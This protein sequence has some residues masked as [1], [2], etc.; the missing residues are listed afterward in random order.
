MKQSTYKALPLIRELNNMSKYIRKY[1]S[2]SSSDTNSLKQICKREKDM[3][4]NHNKTID[5]LRIILA[6]TAYLK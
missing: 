5:Y 1:M 2:F 4:H 3:A 6:K